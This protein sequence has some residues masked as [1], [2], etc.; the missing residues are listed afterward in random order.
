MKR[1]LWAVK[2]EEGGEQKEGVRLVEWAG[3]QCDRWW[4]GDGWEIHQGRGSWR[5]FKCCD[6]MGTLLSNSSS[7][8]VKSVKP[9]AMYV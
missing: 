6:E 9:K 7:L 3:L 2:E 4:L 1:N 8:S 5:N